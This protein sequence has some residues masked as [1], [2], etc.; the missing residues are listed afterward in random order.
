MD[1]Q[2][3]MVP[4]YEFQSLFLLLNSVCAVWGKPA[5]AAGPADVAG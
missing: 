5:G 2:R 3:H 1:K 4:N